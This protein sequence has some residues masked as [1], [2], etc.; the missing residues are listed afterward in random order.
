VERRRE[1]S[2]R[3]GLL[4]LVACGARPQTPASSALG[5]DITLYRDLAVIRQRIEIDVPATPT[6][7]TVMIAAGVSADQ[8]MLIDRGALTIGALHG[9]TD[10]NAETNIG[11][12]VEAAFDIRDEEVDDPLGAVD[13]PPAEDPDEAPEQPAENAMP[14]R[15]AKPTELRLDVSAGR[16]G[17]HAIVIGYVT[18]R[19]PWDVAYTMTATP[20]RDRGVLR[21]AVAIRNSTGITL[22]A[23]NAR[24]VDAEL[25][26][27][28]AKTAEQLA[29]ALV[30]GTPSQ[31]TPAT[32]R[33]LGTLE[34]GSGETRVELMP[35]STRPMSSV[36]V[37]DPIGTKLDNPGAAPLREPRLGISDAASPRVSESF[38]VVR[39][40]AASAGLPAG[41]VRLLERRADSSFVVLGEA[42]LFEATARVAKVDTIA[43]GTADGVTGTRERREL[44]IDD[45]NRRL[46]E[47]FVITLENKRP[48][49]ASV[50]VREHLY[51]GQNWTLAYHSAAAAAKEGPQ[52]IALRAEVPARSQLKILYVVV[53]TWG[54]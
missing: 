32:P 9:L 47:E 48:H 2:L 16:A 43:V 22:R 50:L 3:L 38:E 30:G 54:Q 51:R 14:R 18:D 17:K 52:Q 21:G 24:L 13:E 11:E 1:V 36:L 28:R 45:E 41:A 40:E 25:G 5:D 44:S 20:E 19:L 15:D 4:L 31:T 26:A 39:D 29:A 23:A 10:P 53:Y 35:A 12:P 27:W 34:I 37:Y 49:P 33:E 7:V 46:V 8:V 6:T 42:R